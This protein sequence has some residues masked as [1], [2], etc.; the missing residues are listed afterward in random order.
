MYSDSLLARRRG[1]TDRDRRRQKAAEFM[2]LLALCDLLPPRRKCSTESIAWARR[3]N[4][5]HKAVAS[6]L[7]SGELV[8][9]AC[10]RHCGA[11]TK[12]Q[13]H[14]HRGYDRRN[15]LNVLWLCQ[16]CH[17]AVGLAGAC[18]RVC[19]AALRITERRRLLRE[20]RDGLHARSEALV[21]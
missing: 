13:G 20:H 7:R 19:G 8:A 14:H 21:T 9:D 1:T 17:G 6:A 15:W 16:S 4:K 18:R 11:V 10:C 3:I 2:E 5:A 12:L